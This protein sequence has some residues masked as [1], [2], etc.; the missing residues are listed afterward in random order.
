MRDLRVKKTKKE[1][2]E[3]ELLQKKLPRVVE[4]VHTM[5]DNVLPLF[6]YETSPERRRGVCTLLEQE[7]NVCMIKIRL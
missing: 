6:Q 4:Y 3:E 7:H 2:D 1:E 5:E